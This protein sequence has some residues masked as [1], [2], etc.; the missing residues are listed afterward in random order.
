MWAENASRDMWGV[1]CGKEGLRVVVP[2]RDISEHIIQAHLWCKYETPLCTVTCTITIINANFRYLLSSED[3]A[4]C[5]LPQEA[6]LQH[7]EQQ[8]QVDQDSW[9]QAGPAGEI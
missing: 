8:D 1:G 9:R 5:D 3:G 4:T 6:V 2:P 7:E